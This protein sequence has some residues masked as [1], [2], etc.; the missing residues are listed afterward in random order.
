M[1]EANFINIA[2]WV[3][4]SSSLLAT[5]FIMFN[6]YALNLWILKILDLPKLKGSYTGELISS[7]HIDDDE[8]KPH[9]KKFIVMNIY[10]NLNGFLV[11]AKFYNTKKSKNYTSET[12]SINHDIV[13]KGNGNFTITYL[14]RSKGNKL[15]K[16][17]LKYELNNHEGIAILEYNTAKETLTGNYFNDG[18][19]RTSFGRLNLEKI[20]DE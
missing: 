11:E 7:Y 19:E 15:T 9:V 12:E 17:H 2:V 8:S 20:N 6:K 18:N 3:V 4:G 10:Q 5:F 1:P 13:S 16:E 14:Y